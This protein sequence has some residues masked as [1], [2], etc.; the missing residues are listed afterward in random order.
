MHSTLRRTGAF[1]VALM[2]G[3]AAG[4]SWAA[5]GPPS[6]PGDQHT[7]KFAKTVPLGK[8]G[9]LDVANVSG[10]IIITGGRGDQV[11]INAVKRGK[12]AD[13]LK[14]LEIEVTATA[15]R[16]Q[17]RAGGS[18][19]RRKAK[20]SV[21]FTISV[22]RHATVDVR[23]VSG[24]IKLTAVDGSSRAEAV[25]GDV[26]VA[27]APQLEAAKTV[28][29]DVTI[30]EAGSGGDL[31]VGSVSGDVRV[32]AVRVR[33]L[34][35]NIVSGKLHLLN[36]ACE[37]LKA[38]SISGSLV[39]DGPLAKGG[40]YRF[41]SHSGDVTIY[42]DGKSGFELNASTFS[43]DITTGVELTPTAGA[44]G[45]RPGRTPTPGTGRRVRGTLGD[46]GALIEINAFS[47][48]VKIVKR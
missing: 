38:N 7:E 37:R 27:K 46:G 42:V 9:A 11:V 20:A 12:T 23:S 30:D 6:R 45:D 29:G 35:A 40:R 19:E 28:S 5:P 22:P 43:G 1:A 32:R 24:D 2:I 3:G 48:G 44:E 17:I 39:F 15:N 26:V 31:S 25:S 41:R 8:G 14:A 18:R 33:S 4:S 16:V 47:G 36:V 34:D 21:D 13:D 10:D